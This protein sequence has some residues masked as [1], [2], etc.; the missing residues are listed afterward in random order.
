MPA[1]RTR[2][3]RPRGRRL[4][5]LDTRGIRQARVRR[6]LRERDLAAEAGR[7]V[8][9][10]GVAR[11]SGRRLSGADRHAGL[12]RVARRQPARRLLR[13]RRAL[14]PRALA[15][16]RDR[17]R[18]RVGEPRRDAVRCRPA[19]LPGAAP[20]DDRD[21]DGARRPARPL[22]HR[23]RRR[24]GRRR[25]GRAR[26]FTMAPAPL[27]LRLR[28]RRPG[29]AAPVLGR[30]RAPTGP[31]RSRRSDP[32]PPRARARSAPPCLRI[33]HLACASPRSYGTTRL[34]GPAHE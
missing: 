17:A 22:R 8:H 23:E 15:E 26:L 21:Q 7:P 14:R 28:A 34:T 20:G 31:A 2:R 25:A 29:A 13:R 6:G 3:S 18:G 24:A 1:A 32:R 19:R 33:R 27:T 5:A 11:N 4:G 10:A 12:G 9:H 16:R 30:R